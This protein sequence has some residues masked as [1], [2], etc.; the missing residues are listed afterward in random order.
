MSGMPNGMKIKYQ[1]CIEGQGWQDWVYGGQESGAAGKNKK[2][3]AVRIKLE[4]APDG[5]IVQYQVHM[6]DKGWN[7]PLCQGGEVAG[8]E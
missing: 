8:L 5:Y 7:T 2:L 4:N 6:E 3:E 1:T